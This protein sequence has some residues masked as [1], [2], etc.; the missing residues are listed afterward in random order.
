MVLSRFGPDVALVA[1]ILLDVVALAA[2]WVAARWAAQRFSWLPDELLEHLTGDQKQVDVPWVI[3]SLTGLVL[4]LPRFFLSVTIVGGGLRAGSMFT[5]A[6]FRFF[7]V[8]L[9]VVAGFLA[10][11]TLKGKKSEPSGE[12]NITPETAPPETVTVPEP[13]APPPPP[14]NLGTIALA[15]AVLLFSV[16]N[17]LFVTYWFNPFVETQMK[18][19]AAIIVF[20]T[21][22]AVG[23]AMLSITAARRSRV[24]RVIGST[25]IGGWSAGFFIGQGLIP[26]GDSR[27]FDTSIGGRELIA[28]T[29]GRVGFALLGATIIMLATAA[30]RAWRSPDPVVPFVPTTPQPVTP[31][32]LA[33]PAPPPVTTE[34]DPVRAAPTPAPPTPEPTASVPT[35]RPATREPARAP[36]VAPA[37]AAS[38]PPAAQPVSPPARKKLV[39]AAP[40]APKP[41]TWRVAQFSSTAK[42]S[43]SAI[44]RRFGPAQIAMGVLVLG[45]VAG[46]AYA[47]G[48]GGSDPVR[49][50]AED[51]LPID[52]AAEPIPL[53]TTETV[54]EPVPVET[55]IAAPLLSPTAANSNLIP[56]PG[57]MV[58]I[59][60]EWRFD[61][62]EA[63]S[64]NNV[65]TVRVRGPRIGGFHEAD[66]KKGLA[67]LTL[68][69]SNQGG[70]RWVGS[71]ISIGAADVHKLPMLVTS[72]GC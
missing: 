29:P 10:G 42:P 53:E 72:A 59:Y 32:P 25:A 40:P 69:T 52:Q 68:Q 49:A 8:P 57:C 16:M 33:T 34:P 22:R 55:V 51:Q 38:P 31:Q 54:V 13:A 58:E 63:P 46:S 9:L 45:V 1:L 37:P 28:T 5:F 2:T 3:G 50:T 30:I 65:A 12:L 60:F 43:R 27:F 70:G 24:A 61:P 26:R 47:L 66:Y 56:L 20:A 44:Q 21:L 41:D 35:V 17:G 36:L 11:S 23:P 14:F 71:L 64:R 39:P 67:K 6:H 4:E 48:R 62:A 19:G 7:A 18:W 15:G